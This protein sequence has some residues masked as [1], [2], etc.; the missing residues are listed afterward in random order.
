MKIVNLKDGMETHN[1]TKSQN[2]T[3]KTHSKGT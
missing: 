2:H 3:I 1:Y